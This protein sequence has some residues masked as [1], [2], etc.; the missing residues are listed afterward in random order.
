M[1][2]SRQVKHPPQT[3]Q[4]NAHE[5]NEWRRLA[6]NA[7]CRGFNDRA[8]QFSEAAR[9]TDLSLAEFDALQTVYRAW[10]IEGKL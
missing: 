1:N 9:L 8:F 5:R 10:L 4:P 2:D 3:I 6:S 7:A